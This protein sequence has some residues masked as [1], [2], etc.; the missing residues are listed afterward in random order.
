MKL[1]DLDGFGEIPEE[2]PACRP[3]SMSCGICIC[4]DG[5][6]GNVRRGRVFRA[7]F[8]GGIEAR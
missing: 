7:G 8:S 1:T 5:N 2:F 6:N 4:A 3:F